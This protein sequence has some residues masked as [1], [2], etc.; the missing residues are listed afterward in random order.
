MNGIRRQLLQAIGMTLACAP[1]RILQAQTAAP[2][3]WRGNFRYIY[4][5]SAY[6]DEFKAFL[7]NVFHLYPEDDFHELIR[8]GAE[9]YETDA[10]IYSNLQHQLDDIKPALGDLNYAL[11]AL[12]KQKA[13]MA[14]QTLALLGSDRRYEGYLEIGSNGRYLDSLEERLEIVGDR[15][16]VSER[17]PAYSLVDILDRGQLGSA[18]HYLPLNDYRTDFASAIPRASLDLVT[19]FIGFHHC[20]IPLRDSFFDGIR[21]CMKPGGKLIVRDHDVHDGKMWKVVALAH[22]VFNLGTQESWGYNARELRHFYPLAELDA[23]LT[24]AGFESGGRRL[25][26]DGDPTLN[27]LMM[28]SK[29]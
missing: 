6:R 2:E 26:Q 7:T 14:D 10:E 16:T 25:L 9:A 27:S 13:V 20:P 12:R 28:F 8:R 19:V 1:L 18:G 23:M 21:Q 5:N 11:P 24:K 3:G 4:R 29:R 15:F 22:D 17:A